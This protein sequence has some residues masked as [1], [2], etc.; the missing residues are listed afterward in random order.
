MSFKIGVQIHKQLGRQKLFTTKYTTI[1]T[2]TINNVESL[3][4]H[5]STLLEQ[6]RMYRGNSSAMYELD[7]QPPVLNSRL[8][9]IVRTIV[10]RYDLDEPITSYIMRKHITDG[11]IPAGFQRTILAGWRA[12]P[13][14]KLLI[15]KIYLEEDSCSYNRLEKVFSL[16]R[17]G[18]GL[19][20]ITTDPMTFNNV[21]EL[22]ELIIN[23]KQINNYLEGFDLDYSAQGSIRQDINVGYLN[24]RIEIKGFENISRLSE[25]VSIQ[26]SRLQ[27]LHL[28]ISTLEFDWVTINKH[29]SENSFSDTIIFPKLIEE[30]PLFHA[31][32][33]QLLQGFNHEAYSLLYT[34]NKITFMTSNCELLAVLYNYLKLNK[35]DCTR[36][37]TNDISLSTQFKRPLGSKTRL[38]Y[39]TDL[40]PI[41][42]TK[43]AFEPSLDYFIYKQIEGRPNFYKNS[44]FLNS[45]NLAIKKTS[46][47]LVLKSLTILNSALHKTKYYI[48]DISLFRSLLDLI[49]NDSIDKNFLECHLSHSVIDIF[50]T[51]DNIDHTLLFLKQS[52]TIVDYIKRNL[53]IITNKGALFNRLKIHQN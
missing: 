11:S 22:N 13:S 17:C 24:S 49:L 5:G 35:Y 34:D 38:M 25:L 32:L 31:D 28:Q 4:M 3:V 47:M 41:V 14:G 30:I 7:E 46:F 51:L 52:T 50:K 37:V 21:T 44:Q 2:N 1:E 8:I 39:E 26:L 33:L 9:S 53:K 20:E 12:N 16:D 36:G 10:K 27:S 40:S 18:V 48:T 45:I 15:K 19:V 42:W 23:L 6:N 29:S 43:Y